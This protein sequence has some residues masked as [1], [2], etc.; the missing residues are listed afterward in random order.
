[1]LQFDVCA[2]RIAN[3][4]QRYRVGLFFRRVFRFR[5]PSV[6]Y[7]TRLL[8]SAKIGVH[9]SLAARIMHVFTMNEMKQANC[10][11]FRVYLTCILMLLENETIASLNYAT[12]AY[13]VLNIPISTFVGAEREDASPFVLIN[14]YYEYA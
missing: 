8:S 14:M 12:I 7:S 11:C 13:S 6:I 2:I 4:P 3:I 9:T 1:M 5:I 10:Q